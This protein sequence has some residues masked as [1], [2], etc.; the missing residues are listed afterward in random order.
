MSQWHDVLNLDA[1]RTPAR[2]RRNGLLYV[3]AGA[4][5]FAAGIA[6]AAAWR[7]M[8]PAVMAGTI[9][10]GLACVPKGAL[11][12]ITGKHWADNPHW[13]RIVALVVG[14]P[15]FI[16]LLITSLWLIFRD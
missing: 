14:I 6:L 5:L 15:G 8:P 16:A 12:L 11:Q 13:V 4:V 2:V 1:S 10:V 7:D 9:F 3:L